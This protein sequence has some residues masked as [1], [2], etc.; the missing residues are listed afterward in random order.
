[1]NQRPFQFEPGSRIKL[2]FIKEE[3]EGTFTKFGY[4][5]VTYAGKNKILLYLLTNQG[6]SYIIPVDMISECTLIEPASREPL[7]TKWIPNWFLALL[8]NY[9]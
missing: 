3:V 2:K 5:K 6:F 4:G 1:M 9:K 7:Y 8:P